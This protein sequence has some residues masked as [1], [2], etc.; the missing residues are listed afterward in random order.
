MAAAAYG[1]AD[2]DARAPVTAS[3]LF[4]IGSITKSF[5]GLVV[6]QLQ[7]EGKLGVDQPILRYLPSLPVA[8]AIQ[9]RSRSI[10]SPIGSS[11]MPDDTPVWPSDPTRRAKQ[12][13][14]P[15]WVFS[16]CN[17][18]YQVLKYLIKKIEEGIWRNQAVRRRILAHP[19]LGMND[20]GPIANATRSRLVRSYVPLFDDR[21]YPND[22]PLT[23]A[24]RATYLPADG[25]IASTSLDMAR[26]MQMLL[27]RGAGPRGRIVSPA[28]FEKFT[29]KHIK[30]SELGP[31]AASCGYGIGIDELDGHTRPQGHTGNNA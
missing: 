12:S 13:L 6:L 29:T 21:P 19:A 18:G 1:L 27:N 8:A 5:V 25:G 17:W 3:H 23:P 7:D 28:A 9:Q 26:Y 4:E 11:G 16:Y 22:G 2:L 14:P 31:N 15:G 10:T 24:R 30:A 20:T